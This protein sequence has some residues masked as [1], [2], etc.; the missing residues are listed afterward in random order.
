[1]GTNRIDS[2]EKVVELFG[3]ESSR[4]ES[5]RKRGFT[6]VGD[7]HPRDPWGIALAVTPV[8]GGVGPLTIA[9]LMK[10]TLLACQMRRVQAPLLRKDRVSLSTE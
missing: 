1:V 8:P 4:R 2:D 7:V 5:I 6:L 10:N 9:S 3:E